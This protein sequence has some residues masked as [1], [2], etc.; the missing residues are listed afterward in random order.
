MDYIEYYTS[1]LQHKRD[2]KNESF[3]IFRGFIRG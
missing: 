1:Y 3:F 2:K